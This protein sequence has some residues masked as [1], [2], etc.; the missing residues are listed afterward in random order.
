MAAIARP[1]PS[2]LL[3]V[4]QWLFSVWKRPINLNMVVYNPAS[5]ADAERIKVVL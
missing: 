5:A 2:S 3:G 1:R 4:P